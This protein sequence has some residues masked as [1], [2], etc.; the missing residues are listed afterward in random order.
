ML[1]K[2]LHSFFSVIAGIIFVITAYGCGIFGTTDREWQ[3]VKQKK[4]YFVHT[5]QWQGETL[6]MIARWYTGNGGN[7]KNLADAN[8]VINAGRLMVGDKIFIPGNL[9]KQKK[10]LTKQYVK[11]YYTKRKKTSVVKPQEKEDHLE[12]FGPK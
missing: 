2:R 6:Q 8:P 10:L 12:L 5:V 3:P 1:N 7:W 9:L 11:N 4:K